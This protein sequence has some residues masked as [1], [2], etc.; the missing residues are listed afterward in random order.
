VRVNGQSQKQITIPQLR[1]KLHRERRRPQRPRRPFDAARVDKVRF[2]SV[3]GR[4]LTTPS[5]PDFDPVICPRL[6]RRRDGQEM[7]VSSTGKTSGVAIERLL[8]DRGGAP[9][10]T[11]VL[12][13]AR[14]IGMPV[15][16]TGASMH[17]AA[18][19]SRHSPG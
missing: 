15:N 2:V 7:P 1:A 5:S 10:S 17:R 4:A 18:N 3:L 16:T 19:R 6:N 9:C 13:K 12:A 8:P 14:T 11:V